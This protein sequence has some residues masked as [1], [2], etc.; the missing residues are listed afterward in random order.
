MVISR[1]ATH[2]TGGLGY[3]RRAS[4]LL[5]GA[6]KIVR[7]SKQD[8][9]LSEDPVYLE[10]NVDGIGRY[11]AG[12]ITSMAYGVRTPT[13]SVHPPPSSCSRKLTGVSG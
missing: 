1:G 11:T 13:V 5:N 12:A 2:G 7:D 10:K 9:R 3:Y 6:K 4:S 8:G